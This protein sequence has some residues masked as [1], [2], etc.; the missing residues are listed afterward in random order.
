[1]KAGSLIG[2]ALV[3]I[4]GPVAHAQEPCQGRRRPSRQTPMK[5]FL[6]AKVGL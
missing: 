6:L 4:A 3:M 1:M 5:A 2:L